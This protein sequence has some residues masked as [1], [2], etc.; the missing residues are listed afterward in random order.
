MEVASVK[1]EKIVDN[2]CKFQCQHCPD[3]SESWQELKAHHED[4]H[5]SQASLPQPYVAV[6]DSHYYKCG[7]C[8]SEVLQDN[9]LV[10]LH[11]RLVHNMDPKTF[12][13]LQSEQ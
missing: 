3:I 5:S 1:M 11:I 6:S 13:L 7:F 4:N 2:K 12:A 9:S 10:E 8:G